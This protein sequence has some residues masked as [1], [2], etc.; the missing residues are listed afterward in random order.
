M[1]PA[2]ARFS[3]GLLLLAGLWITVYWWWPSE[4]P[5]SFAADS[6]PQQPTLPAPQPEPTPPPVTPQPQPRPEPSP[7]AV[8]P[9]EFFEHTIAAGETFESVSRRYFGTARHASAIARANPLMDPTRL[10]EGRVIRVPK[11]P[12][13]IQGIPTTQ[14]PPAVPERDPAA[15]SPAPGAREYS[16]QRG[17]T[18]SG[19]SKAM[20]G[21]TRHARLIFEANRDQLSSEDSLIPGQ[22]LKIPPAPK[23]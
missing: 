9:P 23:E 3:V 10:R 21:T 14:T 12:D 16:V 5:V 13:N 22:V 7:P 11:D 15:P 8:I 19:I 4:P 17:D 2:A 1:H 18:L 6:A 20:Y